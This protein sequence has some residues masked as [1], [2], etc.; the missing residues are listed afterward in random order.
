MRIFGCA[1]LFAVC[2]FPQTP[3]EPPVLVQIVRN[4]GFASTLRPYTQ[5]HAALNVLGMLSI[6]GEPETW[7]VEIHNSFAG[8]EALDKAL[9]SLHAPD[10]SSR[11]IIAAYRPGW[12]YR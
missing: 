3:T 5:A 10:R 11:T 6:T 7:A 2:A 8:I 4:T 12:S 1:L 9:A